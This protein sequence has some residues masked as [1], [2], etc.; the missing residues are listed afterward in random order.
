MYCANCGKEVR[1]GAKF[2]NH[3][4]APMTAYE[5]KPKHRTGVVVIASLL[6]LA[7]LI[8]VGFFTGFFDRLLTH[9]EPSP[10]PEPETFASEN[11]REQ[12][13]PEAAE[14]VQPTPDE[15]VQPSSED[16][17]LSERRMYDSDG[18]L[19]EWIAYEYDEH[20]FVTK[21]TIHS[22]STYDGKFYE[23]YTDYQYN[24]LARTM[25]V[26]YGNS[27]ECYA[28]VDWECDEHMNPVS[29]VLHGM[30]EP[31]QLWT[32]QYG[33]HGWLQEEQITDLDGNPVS[34]TWYEYD[35]AGNETLRISED[36]SDGSQR[37]T[38]Y[39]I[40]ATDEHG[41][42]TQCTY[43][44]SVLGRGTIEMTYVKVGH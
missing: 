4:G 9:T 33:V 21:E 32:K 18:V 5:P 30:G 20:G 16:W 44:S 40:N 10:P 43:F 23:D 2:C 38:E 42:V 3:C 36:C 19:V 37:R 6:C 17:K 34:H 28:S 14:Q 29:G 35:E 13:T 39:Q 22:K 12:E 25:T 24:R 26:M 41:K 7:A 31:D 1:E 8:G 27:M 15:Q 11:V